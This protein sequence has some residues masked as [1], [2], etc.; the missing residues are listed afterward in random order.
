MG[1]I[2]REI[3][4]MRSLLVAGDVRSKELYAA[5]QALEW[6]LE[7]DGIQSPYK[8]IMGTLEGKEDC[9]VR[10]HQPLSSDTCFQND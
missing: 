6:V 1:L 2:Q 5:Q 4:R 3:D 9:S 8:M 10:H 7:P